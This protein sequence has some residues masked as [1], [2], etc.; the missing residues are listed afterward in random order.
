MK[1]VDLL[2]FVSPIPSHLIP[3]FATPPTPQSPSNT[4]FISFFHLLLFSRSYQHQ[5]ANTWEATLGHLPR[6]G[7]VFELLGKNGQEGQERMQHIRRSTS[8][9]NGL[10][11]GKKKSLVGAKEAVFGV[12]TC[13]EGSSVKLGSVWMWFWFTC[14]L[15]DAHTISQDSLK[16]L[17]KKVTTHILDKTFQFL[18]IPCWRFPTVAFL[19]SLGRQTLLGS[20]PFSTSDFLL[21]RSRAASSP[22]K[23]P[24]SPDVS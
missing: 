11:G 9:V 14:A 23:K 15:N 17:V 22:E 3:E 21:Q 18:S 12:K 7:L 1:Y 5:E 24:F 6:L 4:V 20:L 8:L 19:A 16:L 10:M 2:W 13:F